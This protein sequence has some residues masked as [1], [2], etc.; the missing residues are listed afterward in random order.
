MV[1]GLEDVG[2][3][4]GGVHEHG[5]DGGHRWV[6]R[7]GDVLAGGAVR[8]TPEV[9]QL[10]EG[11]LA[12]RRVRMGEVVPVEHV[13]GAEMGDARQR[14]AP[15]QRSNA[16]CRPVLVDQ[17]ELGSGWHYYAWYRRA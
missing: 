8:D 15:G 10:D 5:V 3:V 1:G 13:L 2:A 6:G 4:L 16:S 14:P 7:P 9:E 12:G 11:Q 17:A